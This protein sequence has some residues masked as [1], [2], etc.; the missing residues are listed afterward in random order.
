MAHKSDQVVCSSGLLDSVSWHAWS[1]CLC[2]VSLQAMKHWLLSFRLLSC[3]HLLSSVWVLFYTM[4][5]KR[6]L[7]ALQAVEQHRA[8]LL[9]TTVHTHTSLNSCLGFA[10]FGSLLEACAAICFAY[11]LPQYLIV[12]LTVCK[13]AHMRCQCRSG[14]H[15]LQQP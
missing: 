13:C 3:L 10:S 7:A 4:F 11:G 9:F 12:Y 2:H 14:L 6:Q 5:W 15:N 1:Y 8:E